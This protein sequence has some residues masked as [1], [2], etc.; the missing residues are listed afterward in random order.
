M[1]YRITVGFAT[2]DDPLAIPT[3]QSLRLHSPSVQDR[4][5]YVVINNHPVGKLSDTLKKR[6]LAFPRSRY[7][8][9]TDWTG[10]W[11]KYEVFKHAQTELTL[12]VD[13]HVLLPA[14]ALEQLLDFY[15]RMGPT[16]DLYQGPLV[17]DDLRTVQTHFQPQWRGQMYGI[18]GYDARGQKVDMPPFEIP[19]QG[20]GLLSCWTDAFPGTNPLFRGFG[21]EEWY[22]QEKFRQQGGKCWCLPFLRWWHS[23][24]HPDGMKYPITT[25]QKIR[26]YFIGFM[27]LGQDLEPIINHFKKWQSEEKLRATLESVR[28]EMLHGSQLKPVEAVDMPKKVITRIAAPKPFVSSGEVRKLVRK[29]VPAVLPPPAAPGTPQRRAHVSQEAPARRSPQILRHR[30]EPVAPAPPVQVEPISTPAELAL[31][32][33]RSPVSI[34]M[35]PRIVALCPT[36]G[37][38]GRLKKSLAWWER[39]TVAARTLII[40]NDA[41]QIIRCNLPTVLV[42]NWPNRFANL[43]EKRQALLD[44]AAEAGAIHCCHWDDDDI[45]MGNYLEELLRELEQG[46]VAVKPDKAY[47]AFGPDDR[48]SIKGPEANVFES[49]LGF[50]LDS[51]KQIGYKPL[52]G[53]ETLHMLDTW[54]ARGELRYFV[55]VRGYCMVYRFNEGLT[56]VSVTKEVSDFDRNKDFG[57]GSLLQPDDVS[58]IIEQLK[59]KGIWNEEISTA[60]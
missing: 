34:E 50:R 53:P 60:I 16:K 9:F 2:Y 5:D 12:V 33:P 21:G 4:I 27:E 1:S 44:L 36:F 3:L 55:P 39:Q 58:G 51:A 43:G 32:Q 26:N 22:I 47:A 40:L 11:A 19:M 59:Q 18:W 54:R 42:V 24:G 14:N 15:D 41:P 46:A 57:D 37:R 10:T 38:V 49:Q 28:K 30:L 45:Y 31:E 52:Q 48:L 29:P 20:M 17:L 56:H 6:T 23:F 35:T 7:I 8:E 25:D 13:A